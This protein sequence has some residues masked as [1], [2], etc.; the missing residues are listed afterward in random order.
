[1]ALEQTVKQ[2]LIGAIVLVAIAVIFLP[3]ILGQKKDKRTFVSEVPEKTFSQSAEVSND[4]AA[5]SSNS[6]DTPSRAGNVEQDNPSPT[7]KRQLDDSA[8][9][10]VVERQSD[11]STSQL[12]SVNKTLESNSAEEKS[13]NDAPPVAASDSS[14]S[15]S[16]D[17]KPVK[18]LKQNSWVV[19]VGSFS[20]HANAELLS[21]RLEERKLKSFV[22]PV[23]L[24]KEQI[25]YR[26][27]VGPWLQKTQ[28]EKE[29]ENIAD[30][31]RLKPIVVA[32]DPER[33]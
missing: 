12:D 28:A 16:I 3:G 22:R 1:M 32:W 21:K 29:L 7:N 26:V 5:L 27:F 24:D 15:Q 11:G 2:R 20:S 8:K 13:Q 23:E 14:T 19:Q 25:L 30:I 33:Q 17:A 18:A 10:Q 31:T 4:K 6:T 9:R